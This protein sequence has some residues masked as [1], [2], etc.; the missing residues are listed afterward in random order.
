MNT[1]H[2]VAEI[3]GISLGAAVSFERI[4]PI[5]RNISMEQ[6]TQNEILIQVKKTAVWP[7]SVAMNEAALEVDELLDRLSLIDNHRIIKIKYT[8]YEDD[9]GNFHEPSNVGGFYA[10][11]EAGLQNPFEYY[12]LCRQKRILIGRLN[13]GI[14]RLY[15]MAQGMPNGIGKYLLLYGALQVMFGDTQA[16]VDEQLLMR[17][18]DMLLVQGKHRTETIMSNLRNLIAHPE[19]DIDIGNLTN[20][21]E[22]YC[23]ILSDI[24]KDELANQVKP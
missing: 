21:A 16:K 20:Q 18:P 19:N 4:S 2:Y 9:N 11:A 6:L 24:V 22:L 8:G 3:H 5:L 12:E 14:T 13:P 1:Y 7:E 15:R 17:R 23:Q 10:N